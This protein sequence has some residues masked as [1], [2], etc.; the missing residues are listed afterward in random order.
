MV[1]YRAKREENSAVGMLKT[2]QNNPK[3]HQLVAK[4][5]SLEITISALMFVICF[6]FILLVAYAPGFVGASLTG[7]VTTVGVLL[8]LLVIVSAFL[9]T[10]YYASRANAADHSVSDEP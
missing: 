1:P 3:D 10:G 2:N 4:R 8:G 6:G 7:G 5:R 9:L